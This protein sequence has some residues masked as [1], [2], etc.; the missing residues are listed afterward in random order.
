VSEG[1]FGGGVWVEREQDGLRC[2]GRGRLARKAIADASV[3]PL[4]YPLETTTASSSTVTVGQTYPISETSE[5]LL[6]LLFFAFPK[7]TRLQ[8]QVRREEWKKRRRSGRPLSL[9]SF[10]LSSSSSSSFS[11]C[12]P[13]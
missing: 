3:A 5:V 6:Q 7:E 12:L 4:S 9:F 10:S 13:D 11:P 2:G 1:D 8:R